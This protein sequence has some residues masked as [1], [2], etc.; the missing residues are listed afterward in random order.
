MCDFLRALGG[1][2]SMV[3]A[4]RNGKAESEAARAA[5]RA[6]AVPSK[7]THKRLSLNLPKTSPP[8]FVPAEPVPD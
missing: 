3:S 1:F 7:N 6:N 8:P 5:G 4:K 2:A